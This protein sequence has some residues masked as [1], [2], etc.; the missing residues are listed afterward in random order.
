MTVAAE[1]TTVPTVVLLAEP[2]A[3]RARR[4]LLALHGL[5]VAPAVVEEGAGADTS[6]DEGTEDSSG[7]TLDIGA[8]HEQVL[9]AAGV[10][11]DDA[12]PSAWADVAGAVDGQA[13]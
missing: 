9:E 3:G 10:R 13:E 6:D 8:M 7:V 12:R 5:G 11:G 4:L 1:P 2:G